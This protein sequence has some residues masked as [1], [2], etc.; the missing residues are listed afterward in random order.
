MERT[1]SASVTAHS[2]THFL[3][4]N[5]FGPCAPPFAQS[6]AVITK[7]RALA[8]N[9]R[10]RKPEKSHHLTVCRETIEMRARPT[11]NIAAIY[12]NLDRV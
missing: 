10:C 5:S 8:G 3:G 9:L 7:D 2:H 11:L 12:N 6:S 1:G 4:F